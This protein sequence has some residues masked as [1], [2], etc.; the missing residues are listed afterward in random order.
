M[1]RN[2]VNKRIDDKLYFFFFSEQVQDKSEFV[3][4]DL[5]TEKNLSAASPQSLTRLAVLS[6][7]V[8]TGSVAFWRGWCNPPSQQ[9]TVLLV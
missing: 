9:S 1:P 7:V 3:P 5:I 2:E 8:V 4:A 6:V